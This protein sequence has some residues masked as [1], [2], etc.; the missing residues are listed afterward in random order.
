MRIRVNDGD[1]FSI[2]YIHSVHVSP[3]TEFFEIRHGQI[4]LTATEFKTFGAGMPTE[5]E[6]G[7]ALVHIPDGG[8]RIE[9][10]NRVINTLRYIIGYTTEHTFHIGT[11]SI[12]LTDLSVP[13]Q[14]VR[15]DVVRISF[16]QR[17]LPL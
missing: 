14:T 8:M 7:Q 12:P 10:F 6:P 11:Q 16:W 2:S 5:I 9:G 4:V 1:E 3:V 13:G 15:F 17:F